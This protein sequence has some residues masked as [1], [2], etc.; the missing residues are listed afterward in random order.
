MKKILVPTDFSD[1]S[2]NA[3][4]FALTFA[5]KIGAEITLFNSIHYDYFHDYQYGYHAALQSM[6]DEIR[7]ASEKRMKD[8]AD[9]FVGEVKIHTR[10]EPISIVSAVKELVEDEGFD[11]VIV[12][13]HGASGL[14]EF[15]IG[16]NTEKIVRHSPCPVISVPKGAELKEIKKVLIPIDLRELR[17]SF[18]ETVAKIQQIFGCELEFVW[19]KTPHNIENEEKVGKELAELF[20]SHGIENYKFFI[21]KHVFPTD[22]ILIEADE[23]GAD[24][25]AMATHARRGIS[26]WLSGSM[27]EDTVNHLDIP[28]WSFRINKEEK[29]LKLDAVANAK[30]KP[31]YKKLDVV[32]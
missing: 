24:M 21:V 12:G 15:L 26:H 32:L 27:T 28:V 30:G 16:S 5:K 3:V 9:K 8:F 11:Y 19:V 17:N 25:V 29:V 18:L 23:I 2:E 20:K 4:R 7:D 6:I 13:T 1:I 10:I 31:L 22:G 14:E